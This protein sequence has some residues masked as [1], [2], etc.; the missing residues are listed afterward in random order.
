VAKNHRFL[1]MPTHPAQSVYPTRNLRDQFGRAPEIV[2]AHRHTIK[3]KYADGAGQ[4]PPLG[5]CH[6]N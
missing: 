5:H 4:Q 6:I 1:D 3:S 2:L